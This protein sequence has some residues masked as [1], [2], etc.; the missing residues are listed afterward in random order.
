MKKS[1]ILSIVCLIALVTTSQAQTFRIPST[2]VGNFK[3][4]TTQVGPDTVTNAVT[5]FQYAIIDGYQD[6]IVV[7]PTFTKVS[8]TAAATVKLQ[9]SV[10]GVSYNDVGSPASY[11]V[12][13]TATQ[14]VAFTVTGNPYK[15]YR[16]SIVPTG[17]QSLRVNTP[18][19]VRLRSTR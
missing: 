5:L 7:Q 14:S 1:I 17:T 6:S 16:L 8:G 12:T 19:L 10:N 11:T 9:G 13:D 4:T 15:Y 2:G 3:S 18:V